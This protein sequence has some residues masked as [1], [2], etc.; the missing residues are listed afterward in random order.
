M[1]EVWHTVEDIAQ[2]LKLDPETV[3][4]NLQRG[5]LR[6]AKFGRVW[7][8]SEDDLQNFINKAKKD[9]SKPK[10]RISLEGIISGS[11]VTDEDFEEVK[12]QWYSKLR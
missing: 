6:G 3:R 5:N 1:T 4:R 2:M 7:R 10:K 11:K 9:S 8:V 12:K